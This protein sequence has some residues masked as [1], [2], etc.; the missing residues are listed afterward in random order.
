MGML[1]LPKGGEEARSNSKGEYVYRNVG[2]G[3]YTLSAEVAGFKESPEESVGIDGGDEHNVDFDLDPGGSVAGTV[4]DA[5]G[6]AVA[7][8]RVRLLKID[9]QSE[10]FRR[11]QKYFG[12]SYKSTLA[13]DDG[14]FII[15][16]LP[17]GNYAVVGEKE[18]FR[19]GEL[20][21][22]SPGDD[23]IRIVPVSYTHLRAHE[24]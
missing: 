11:A 16:G 22:V 10:G 18:G 9:N 17:E 4:V 3:Q 12:G 19:K 15:D 20:E 8:A 13:E 21:G 14:S 5:A 1:G 7:G 23:K 2:I 24:T 6:V